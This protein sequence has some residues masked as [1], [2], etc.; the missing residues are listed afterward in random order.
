MKTVTWHYAGLLHAGSHNLRERRGGGS[1]K[2]LAG[3]YRP[4][5]VR[6]TLGTA[7]TSGPVSIDLQDDGTS[8]FSN[9]PGLPEGEVDGGADIFTAPPTTDPDGSN[10][11]ELELQDP[12]LELQVLAAGNGAQAL[13]VELDLEEI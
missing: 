12:R 8:L 7:S 4:V 10:V 6:V 3:R 5:E 13:T 2:A 11:A 9:F 1:L